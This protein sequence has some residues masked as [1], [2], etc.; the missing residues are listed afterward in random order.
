MEWQFSGTPEVA[1]PG[2]YAVLVCYDPREGVFPA[3]AEWDGSNW[4]HRAVV[5][6]GDL[7]ETAVQAE[8]LAYYNDLGDSQ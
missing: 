2:W 7:C 8:D 3:S 5:A 6:F 1:A 4:M